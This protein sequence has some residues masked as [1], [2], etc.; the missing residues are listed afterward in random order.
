MS[1]QTTASRSSDGRRQST[2]YQIRAALGLASVMLGTLLVGFAHELYLGP[3]DKRACS[4][5]NVVIAF[6]GGFSAHFWGGSVEYRFGM[7]GRI[8]RAVGGVAVFMI[9]YLNPAFDTRAEEGSVTIEKICGVEASSNVLGRVSC[10]AEGTAKG[11]NPSAEICAELTPE[12]SSDTERCTLPSGGWWHLG[13]F[14]L[15]G[16]EEITA[17]TVEFRAVARDSRGLHRSLAEAAVVIHVP[18][19]KVSISSISKAPSLCVFGTATDVRADERLVIEAT[20]I[21]GGAG[22]WYMTADL[23]AGNW[24]ACDR[25]DVRVPSADR[26]RIAVWLGV[27]SLERS[28]LRMPP[29]YLRL[30]E[31]TVAL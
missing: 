25:P 12:V 7:R 24:S 15:R 27:G 4:L 28:L 19:P 29:G 3:L 10:T 22:T 31:E 11:L 1:T 8:L 9:L 18:T 21:T 14:E 30:S 20:P 13:P 23:T 2:K 26:Y 16:P 6:A 5:L 17:R